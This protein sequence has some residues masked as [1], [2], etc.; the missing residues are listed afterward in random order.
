MFRLVS[1][2]GIGV[3]RTQGESGIAI[4]SV[5]IQPGRVCW[6]GT[7]ESLP[8]CRAVQV[9]RPFESL[10]SRRGRTAK[11][12]EPLS[13]IKTTPNG[14]RKH[15]T[16]RSR[17][18]GCPPIVHSGTSTATMPPRQRRAAADGDNGSSTTPDLVRA[19]SEDKE[20]AN[21]DEVSMTK[22]TGVSDKITPAPSPAPSPLLDSL[23]GTYGKFT[24][25]TFTADQGLKIIQWSSWAISYATAKSH[26]H[27]LSPGL[28][29]LYGEISMTRY[30]LRFYGFLQSLEGFRSGSWAGGQW[31]DGR[32]AKLAK[33]AM[34]GR[35]SSRSCYCCKVETP[36]TPRYPRRAVTD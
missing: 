26:K 4:R 31:N 11:R 14:N 35:C 15:A 8:L 1:M 18:R 24:A 10:S 9:F 13:Y 6:T 21:E 7:L 28:R 32:I 34:A 36:M 25:S 29:K 20:P 23:L 33:Y 27:G 17:R 5:R 30:V 2:P 16:K 19:D 3:L 12:C 22:S